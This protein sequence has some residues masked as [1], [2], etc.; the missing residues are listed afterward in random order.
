[1]ELQDAAVCFLLRIEEQVAPA[2]DRW[3]VDGNA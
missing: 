2:D 3:G 1:M